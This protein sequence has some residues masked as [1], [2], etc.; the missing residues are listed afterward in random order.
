M[1]RRSEVDRSDAQRNCPSCS[2]TGVYVDEDG[3]PHPCRTCGGAGRVSSRRGSAAA[4]ESFQ[5]AEQ[6]AADAAA[7]SQ[8]ARADNG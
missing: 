4:T 7:R 8:R 1:P 6:Q 3:H 5:R 2:G